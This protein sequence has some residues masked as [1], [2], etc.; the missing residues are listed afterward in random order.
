[1]SQIHSLYLPYTTSLGNTDW[2]GPWENNKD[3]FHITPE[4]LDRGATE[5]TQL[6]DVTPHNNLSDS[7]I[8]LENTAEHIQHSRVVKN[9]DPGAPGWLRWKSLRL[10]ILRV[11]SSSPVVGVDYLSKQINVKTKTQT[12]ELDS[13]RSDPSPAT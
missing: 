5:P 13:V 8:T 4:L 12:L 9:T 6:A 1:M 3:N 7:I 2:K 10:L 11:V